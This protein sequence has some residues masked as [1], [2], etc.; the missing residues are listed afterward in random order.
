MKLNMGSGNTN[1]KGYVNCDVRKLPNVEIVCPAWDIPLDN[2]VVSALY[3][4]HMIEHLTFAQVR[5]TLKEWYRIMQDGG[6]L[7]VSCPD[8]D[9]CFRIVREPETREPESSE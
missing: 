5:Q 4:R 1:F 2:E 8:I 6:V 9:Y 3:S 7:E